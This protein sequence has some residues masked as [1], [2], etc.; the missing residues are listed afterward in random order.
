MK[1]TSVAQSIIQQ[2]HAKN[3]TAQKV[4]T[5]S[6]EKIFRAKFRHSVESGREVLYAQFP[7]KDGRIHKIDITEFFILPN[8]WEPLAEGFIQTGVTKTPLSRKKL[9]MEQ[10]ATSLNFLAQVT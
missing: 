1:K 3:I 8:L 5:L 9:K 2:V 7:E 4:I 10:S 6:T